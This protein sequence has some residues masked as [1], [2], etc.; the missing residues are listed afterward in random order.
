MDQS[1]SQPN[2]QHREVPQ[3]PSSPNHPSACIGRPE[4]RVRPMTVPRCHE[5]MRKSDPGAMRKQLNL[6]GALTASRCS[7]HNLPRGL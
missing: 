1:P 2:L 6:Q 3:P 5:F 7:T 4:T